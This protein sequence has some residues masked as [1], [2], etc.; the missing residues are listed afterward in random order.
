LGLLLVNQYAL[1]L[2]TAAQQTIP[3]APNQA[4]LQGVVVF[5]STGQAVESATVRLVGTDIETQTGRYGG[6]AFPDVEPGVVSVHVSAVGHPSVVQEVEVAADGIVFIQFRLPSIAAVLSEL[7]VGAQR[8]GPAEV[9]LTAADLLVAEVPSTRINT[10]IVGRIDYQIQL[11]TA[12]V[13]FTESMEPLIFID[14]VLMSRLGQALQTLSQ[15]PASDVEHI[16]VLKGPAAAF[17]YPMAANG[18][19]LVTTRSGGRRR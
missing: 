11:R 7:L 16:E 4:R 18:V 1:P 3:G 15:I 14:D 13:S 5:E 12:G 8:D 2:T 6:F 10:G 17:R 9:G 19:V